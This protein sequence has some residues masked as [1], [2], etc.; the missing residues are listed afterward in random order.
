MNIF[1]ITTFL[2]YFLNSKT[3]KKQKNKESYEIN[4]FFHL[5]K[6]TKTRP[7]RRKNASFSKSSSSEKVLPPHIIKNIQINERECYRWEKRILK[8]LDD[9]EG[10]KILL[11]IKEIGENKLNFQYIKLSEKEKVLI[12]LSNFYKEL[13]ALSVSGKAT[14][15]L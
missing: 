9:K 4:N 5:T 12:I 1:L 7:H 10:D 11:N 14:Y 2:N 13:N 6:T 15:E 8:K 3:K